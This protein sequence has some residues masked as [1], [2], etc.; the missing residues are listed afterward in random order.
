M[1][2][3]KVVV[4]EDIVL[5]ADKFSWNYFSEFPPPPEVLKSGT[6]GSIT[7]YL[8]EMEKFG[9]SLENGALL[10]FNMTEKEFKDLFHVDFNEGEDLNAY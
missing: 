3:G 1:N 10:T 5:T 9:I 8:P 2:H 6:V 4:K 7:G